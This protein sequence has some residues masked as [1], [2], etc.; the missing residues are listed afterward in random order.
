MIL[1]HG[2]NIE[3]KEPRLIR[4]QRNLD[5]GRGFYTTSDLEQARQWAAR[6]TR[7]RNGGLAQIS[8]YEFNDDALDSLRVLTFPS[9]NIEWLRFV[10]QHRR[11]THIAEEYDIVVGPVANDQTMRTIND[12]IRGRF[13]ED[14]AIR[15]L[16]P[17]RLKDQ[18]VFKTEAALRTLRFKEVLFA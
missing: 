8:V 12:Y 17:E 9:A 15:L 6:T 1:Y 13:P 4:T 2:S 5:F 10:A 3:V 7:I 16:R 18:H 11:G 14:V